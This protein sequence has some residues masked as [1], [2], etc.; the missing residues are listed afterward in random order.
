MAVSPSVKVGAT[1]LGECRELPMWP[2][3]PPRERILRATA[4]IVAEHGISGASVKLVTARAGVSSRT[5]Y[6]RFGGLD[7]CLIAI[8]DDT[9]ERVLELVSRAFEG[10]GAWQDGMRGALAEVLAFF[11]ARPALARVCLVETLSGDRAVLE[12][13][14][15]VVEGFRAAVVA[16]IEGQVTH[17]SP[18]AAEG[19]LASVMGIAYERLRAGEPRSL[20]EMLGPLMG[21]IAAQTGDQR[22]AAEEVRRG[23]QLTR[24]L[25]AA[26]PRPAPSAQPRHDPG[27]ATD[28]TLPAALR[29]PHAR[30][31]RECL[32]FLAEQSRLGRRPS[33]REVAVA[34]GVAHKSQISSLLRCLIEEGLVAKRSEGAGKPNAWELT[35]S[36]EAAALAVRLG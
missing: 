20:I 17:P 14:R 27:C 5:F 18:L 33:N 24:E 26:A 16:H 29:N 11:D 32:L 23:E 6:A 19:V 12:R 7:D 28:A 30:R 3:E 8:M 22:L 25:M 13:R 9:L 34:I 36:G 31:A 15:Q 10:A 1:A 2:P 35:P 4:E 21:L